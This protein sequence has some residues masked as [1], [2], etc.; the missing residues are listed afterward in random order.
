MTAI[1][2]EGVEGGWS[3][4]LQERMHQNPPR[5]KEQ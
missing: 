1:L 2:V 4:C 5:I 3:A